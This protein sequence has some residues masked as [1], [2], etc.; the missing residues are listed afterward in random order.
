MT[1]Q[2]VN[3]I[4]SNEKKNGLD[5]SYISDGYHTFDELY[6]ARCLLF[7][8][9]IQTGKFPSWKASANHDGQKW[10][11]WFVAGIFPEDG[12][13]I[14]YHLPD[15]YWDRLDVEAHDINPY[16]DGHDSNEVLHRLNDLTFVD[17]PRQGNRRH[18][19]D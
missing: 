11:G 1:V 14:T 7:V 17:K 8:A 16:Y 2:E 10:D 15:K 13:Q 3:Q 5:S 18:R 19:A 6:E 4:I 12:R 9:L